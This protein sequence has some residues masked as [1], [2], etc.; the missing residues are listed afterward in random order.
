M[1]TFLEFSLDQE[2]LL[3]TDLPTAWRTAP[4]DLQDAHGGPRHRHRNAHGPCL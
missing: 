3:Y 1:S 2:Y 4:L